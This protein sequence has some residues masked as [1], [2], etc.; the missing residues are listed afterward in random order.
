MRAIMSELI[1]VGYINPLKYFLLRK[2][3]NG[4]FT[5][6]IEESPDIEQETELSA[7]NVE[8]AIREAKKLWKTEG[9]R[10]MPCGFRFTLPERDEHGSNALFGQAVKS[11]NSMTGVYYDEE[12]G[13]NCIVHQIPT[14]VRD[15]YNR[16]KQQNRL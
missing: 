3:K 2:V 4:H 8:E 16:L 13:H 11:L 9:F 5:W 7:P 12:L 14:Q 1:H 6:F 10:L 15:F